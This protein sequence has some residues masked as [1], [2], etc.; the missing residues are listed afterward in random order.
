M[1]DSEMFVASFRKR[2]RAMNELWERVPDRSGRTIPAVDCAMAIQ[3][4]PF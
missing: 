1:A 4:S 3:H 2:T